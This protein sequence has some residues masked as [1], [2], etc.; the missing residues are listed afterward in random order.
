MKL[1]KSLLTQ[2]K[3]PERNSLETPLLAVC[4]VCKEQ[5]LIVARVLK[6]KWPRCSCRKLMRVRKYE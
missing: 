3:I 1:T 5:R 4:S 2:T 6:N